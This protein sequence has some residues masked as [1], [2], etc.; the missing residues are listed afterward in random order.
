MSI[1][2]RRHGHY[3]D[4]CPCK[5][6]SITGIMYI[7]CLQNRITNLT[8]TVMACLQFDDTPGV[9]IEA[10]NIHIIGKG[11]SQRQTY[12]TQTYH[13]HGLTPFLQG[14][15]ADHDLILYK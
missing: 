12:I 7:C 9:D 4:R 3:D 1:N 14:F 2:G 10:E 15:E 8:G 5:L 6:C 13:R 11:H